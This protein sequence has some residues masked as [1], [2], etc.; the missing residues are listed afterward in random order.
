VSKIAAHLIQH[1]R[2]IEICWSNRLSGSQPCLVD[3]SL[4]G[5][6]NQQ[7]LT[8]L[9]MVD[10]YSLVIVVFFQEST[11]RYTQGFQFP[12]ALKIDWG[13][14]TWGSPKIHN[15]NPSLGFEV[16]PSGK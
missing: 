2:D 16:L 10:I 8:Q 5:A 7:A 9:L 4:G 3:A 15:S 11:C 12:L 14:S 13:V 6:F 1:F